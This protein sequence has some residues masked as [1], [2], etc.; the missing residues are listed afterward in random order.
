MIIDIHTHV[1]NKKIWKEYQKES[2]GAV[3]KIIAIPYFDKNSQDIPRIPD[4]EELLEFTDSE[5]SIFSLGSINM[6]S[7]LESQLARHEELLRE[8]RIVGIKL[9]T[10]YQYFYPHDEKVIRIG[11]LCGKY[12]RPLIFHIGDCFDPEDRAILKYAHPIHIDDLA[13]LCPETNIVIS[14]F[15]FPYFLETGNVVA[16]NENVYVDISAVMVEFDTPEATRKLQE[17][18]RDDLRRVFTYFPIIKNRVMF[19][20]DFAGENTPLKFVQ[21]YI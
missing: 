11:K 20:T 3:E 5:P 16:S 19:G 17:Q 15:G 2:G 4:V 7:D 18:Y 1:C 21:P 10:G 8:D 13:K 14:H 9:Y 6:D 12:K